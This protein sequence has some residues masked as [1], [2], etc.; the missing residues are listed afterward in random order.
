MALGLSQLV[1]DADAKLVRLGRQ[2]VSG[3]G[4]KLKWVR[5]WDLKLNADAKLGKVLCWDW[6]GYDLSFNDINHRRGQS[7]FNAVLPELGVKPQHHCIRKQCIQQWIQQGTRWWAN[8]GP[9]DYPGSGLSSWLRS[10]LVRCWKQ[11]QRQYRRGRGDT[12]RRWCSCWV[13]QDI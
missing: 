12:T 7:C 9:Q 13:S 4:S 8:W 6:R 5:L 3:I 11:G 1:I 10:V 2:S